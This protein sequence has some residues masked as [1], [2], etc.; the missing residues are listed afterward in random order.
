MTSPI[1][2]EPVDFRLLDEA[3][4]KLLG[5]YAHR[6]FHNFLSSIVAALNQQCRDGAAAGMSTWDTT[7]FTLDLPAPGRPLPQRAALA[8]RG[9]RT[10]SATG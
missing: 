8:T 7:G 9:A 4:R 2:A 1:P 3:S 5:Y 10:D 6:K